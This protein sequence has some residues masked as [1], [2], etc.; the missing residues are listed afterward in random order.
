VLGS[1]G[2]DFHEGVRPQEKHRTGRETYSI[3]FE[4]IPTNKMWDVPVAVP[5]AVRGVNRQIINE[6]QDS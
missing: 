3:F 4:E 6:R 2:D 1:K 5:S